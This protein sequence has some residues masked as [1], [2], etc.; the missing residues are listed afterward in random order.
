MKK[1]G[2]Q[3]RDAVKSIDAERFYGPSEA[4]DLAKEAARA[5]L[6]AAIALYFSSS[7]SVK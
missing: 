1:R 2:K 6:L 7:V 4:V 5:K 3:Y